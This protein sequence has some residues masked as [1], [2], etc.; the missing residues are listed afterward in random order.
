MPGSTNFQQWNPSAANQETDAQYTT[1]AQRVGGAANPAIFDSATAN[2]VLY[3]VTTFVAALA[4]ALAA[5]GFALSDANIN[6]LAGVLATVTTATDLSA[7]LAAYAPLASPALTGA[8]T[9][10]TAAVGDN[11]A[12][13]A[14]TAFVKQQ[15]YL[16]AIS[17]AMVLAALGFTPI[18]QGGGAGQG[19]NKVRIGWD[20][21]ANPHLRVQ[22][23]ATDCGDL[24]YVSDLA[25]YALTSWTQANFATFAWTIANFIQP[26]AFGCSLSYNGYQRIQNGLIIQWGNNLG[27]GAGFDGAG[28]KLVNWTFPIAFPNAVFAV[29]FTPFNGGLQLY[30]TASAINGPSSNSGTTCSITLDAAH[31][32]VGGPLAVNGIAIGF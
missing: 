25:P 26:S 15:G 20:P 8:P 7:A 10:P 1:D 19:T 31:T 22:I 32:A 6:A 3:Q 27:N 5:K 13:L 14:N 16:T 24:A 11:T 21:A 17:G 30:G 4:Q 18:Q 29:T 28:R 2:K 9:A 23:D 12:K